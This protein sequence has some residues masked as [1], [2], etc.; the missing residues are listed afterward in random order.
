MLSNPNL[1]PHK[2]HRI[3]G[4][5]FLPILQ[6]EFDLNLEGGCLNGMYDSGRI[7]VYLSHLLER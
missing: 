2:L 3:R 7:N 6:K 4:A 5:Y 1:L